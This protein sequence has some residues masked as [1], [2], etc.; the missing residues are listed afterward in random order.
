MFAQVEGILLDSVY[1]AKAA[2]A[3]IS[4]IENGKCLDGPVLFLHTGGNGGV[5]Y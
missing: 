4:Y 1:T 3:M 2:A 5:Y